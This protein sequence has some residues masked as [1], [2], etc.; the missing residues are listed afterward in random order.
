[1]KNRLIKGLDLWSL[2][3]DSDQLD[4]LIA[5]LEEMLHWNRKINLTAITE[6]G[7]ALEKHLIDSLLMLLYVRTGENLI[8]LGSGA[9]LP[10]IPLAIAGK[11][12]HIVS[13]D[14]V[15]KKIN[16]QKHVIRKLK[17]RSINPINSRVEVLAQ[18]DEFKNTFDVVTA[19]AFTSLPDIAMVAT[20]LLKDQGRILAMKGAEGERE[21]AAAE[22]ELKGLGFTQMRVDTYQLPFS[23]AVRTIVVIE[24]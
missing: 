14:S 6:P 19:R 24:K 21:L 2:S 20:S 17:L 23:R 15:G 18:S 7:E 3:C 12:L 9:G 4:K 5:Y 11:D 16:F 10:A 22:V 8:D 1:M 13:V